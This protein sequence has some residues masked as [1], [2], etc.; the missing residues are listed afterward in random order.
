MRRFLQ[1]SALC[2]AA[3]ALACQPEE[4]V[5]TED[6][7]TA[8]VRFIHAVPDTT[9]MDF[10]AVDIVENSQF[11]GIVYRPTNNVFYKNARA[12]ARHFKIFLTPNTNLPS[13][14]QHAMAST[15]IQDIN[16]TLEAGHNY[17]FIL[18]GYSKPGSP[19]SP[20]MKL[21]ILDDT[22]P[23]PGA[24]IAIRVLNVAG[25]GSLDVKAYPSTGAPPGTATWASV[26]PQSASAYV[27]MAPAASNADIRFNVTPAGGGAALF[28]DPNSGLTGI[29]AT[30]DIEATPGTR[31]AGSALSAIVFPRSVAGTGAPQG[32]IGGINYGLPGMMFVWD[33]RPPRAP[34]L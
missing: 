8:G 15:V 30:V 29:P 21:D 22:P 33:R 27:S 13:A 7:P 19:N 34:G 25:L 26:G 24:N 2:L 28:T 1:L 17:T 23:D 12:G 3:G 5:I 14:Q 10:R 20:A 4:V 18:W 31:I 16:V 32:T 11:Y 9:G 6:I